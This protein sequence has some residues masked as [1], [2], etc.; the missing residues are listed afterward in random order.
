P[1]RRAIQKHLQDP[2]ALLILKGEFREGDSVLVDADG[3]TG[4]SFRKS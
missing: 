4:F 2:L 3:N 1:L